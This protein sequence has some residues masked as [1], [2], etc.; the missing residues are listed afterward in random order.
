VKAIQ[1]I[2]DACRVLGVPITGGNVS[3][4]NETDG[5]AIHPTPVV[6]V[7]GLLEDAS[8]VLTSWFR[9]DDD[10]VLLLGETH[11]D[12]GGSE[13]LEVVHGRV[14][15]R[16]PRLDLEAEK[17]LHAL[18]LEAAAEGWLCSAHDP[19][20]GGLAVALAE[21]AF[22]G[23][24]PGRG[25]RFDLPGSLRPDVLLFSESPSRMIVTTR[26]E[27]HVRAAAHRHGVSCA[28]LGTV[29]GDR[30]TLLSGS[31]VLVDVPVRRLHEAWMSLE[32]LLTPTA[33]R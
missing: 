19:S 21:C 11:D 24:E 15:G 1:G 5:A 4:Y 8:K 16:P 14:A 32:A 23:E 30:L 20:D 10:V 29:G 31:R 33:A 2:G 7:V 9:E 26:E 6:G 28:R 22:R 12:L 27:A 17:R 25:G 3:L 13:L 18:V